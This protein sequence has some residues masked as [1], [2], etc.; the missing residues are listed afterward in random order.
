MRRDKTHECIVWISEVM[1]GS[2][3]TLAPERSKVNLVTVHVMDL[4]LSSSF[5]SLLS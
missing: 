2:A 5:S 3:G 4:R 1:A